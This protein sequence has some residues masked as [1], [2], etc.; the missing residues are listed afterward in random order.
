MIHVAE[1]IGIL[2]KIIGAV[3]DFKLSI[4]DTFGGL[5]SFAF[6]APFMDDELICFEIDR[7]K[8]E[9]KQN[10]DELTQYERFGNDGEYAQQK[11]E[12]YIRQVAIRSELAYLFSHNPAKIDDCLG[13]LENIIDDFKVC[14]EA[15]K[16]YTQGNNDLAYMGFTEYVRLLGSIP[17]HFMAS[18]MFG[19]LLMKRQ[20]YKY[21]IP[22]LRKASEKRPDDIEVH[23]MLLNCY[24][25]LGMDFE[26]GIES[27]ITRLL[28][29]DNLGSLETSEEYRKLSSGKD[30]I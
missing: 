7:L 15:M 8:A 4:V 13:L 2:N 3:R 26:L 14:L 1:D 20:R 23:N 18:K 24:R 6:E 17:E 29:C 25:A 27:T 19:E 9:Y 16:H 11:K 22:F 5:D 28:T 12:L 30:W 21:A 10:S